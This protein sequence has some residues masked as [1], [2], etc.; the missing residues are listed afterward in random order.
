[1]N[2]ISGQ[3]TMSDSGTILVMKNPKDP[4]KPKDSQFLNSKGEKLLN[5]Y[6][7]SNQE[8]VL[9]T[10]GILNSSLILCGGFIVEENIGISPINDC[11]KLNLAE[12][13]FEPFAEK[14]SDKRRFAS[15]VAL[16]DSN[17][18]ITGGYKRENNQNVILESTDI[19]KKDGTTKRSI[20]LKKGL[21]SHCIT[22]R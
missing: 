7:N 14:M 10:G 16:D 5:F 20:D 4:S 17:L 21:R 11:Y 13:I 2:F 18:W 9:G 8:I 22:L 19:V 15:S 3:E 1:M 6:P 12:N